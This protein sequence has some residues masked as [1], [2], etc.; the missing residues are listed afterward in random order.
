MTRLVPGRASICQR[1]R[2]SFTSSGTDSGGTNGGP[3][4]EREGRQRERLRDI[5]LEMEDEEA[6]QPK[7]IT[8]KYTTSP[9]QFE[10]HCQ[11]RLPYRNWSP[12]CVQAKRKSP[13]HRRVTHDG[14]FPVISVDY[15]HMNGSMEDN[16]P[17]LVLHDTESQGVWAIMGKRKGD[18]EYI[19][20]HATEIITK[21]GY[22]KVVSKSDREHS[23]EIQ[24]IQDQIIAIRLDVEINMKFIHGRS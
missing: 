13:G 17:I 23:S 6:A 12:T 4:R 14:G 2:K 15:M 8:A 20:R 18:D 21:L 9:E 22:M 19:V 24:R 3:E 10:E 5:E 11:T 7:T 16:C 1:S